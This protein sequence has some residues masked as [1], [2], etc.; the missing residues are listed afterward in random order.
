[1]EGEA[2]HRRALELARLVGEISRRGEQESAACQKILQG[3]AD[4]LR[5]RPEDSDDLMGVFG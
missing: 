2:S 4:Y 3:F 1:M 5:S